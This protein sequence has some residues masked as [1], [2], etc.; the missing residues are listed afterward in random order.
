MMRS[1]STSSIEVGLCRLSQ[2]IKKKAKKKKRVQQKGTHLLHNQLA[3][4][5]LCVVTSEYPGCST[6]S[7]AAGAAIQP[8]ITD[9]RRSPSSCGV[10][11]SASNRRW[12]GETGGKDAL[13]RLH[14]ISHVTQE[15]KKTD[16]AFQ[17]KETVD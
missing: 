13:V 10:L 5:L 4:K 7:G 9:Y 2:K 12:I 17:E 6:H 16:I 1:T 11:L 8:S 14:V 3:S 15:E